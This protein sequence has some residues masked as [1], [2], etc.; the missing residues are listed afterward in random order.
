[1]KDLVL[2]S[3]NPGK[4][5]E[6]QTILNPI[7]CILQSSLGIESAEET[8]LSFIENALIKARHAS[9]IA[10]KPALADDS[11][12]V[13]PIIDGRPGIYSARFAGTHATDQQNIDH[14]L[15]ALNPY[16]DTD[17]QA[18]F[19]CALAFVEHADDPTPI[20]ATAAFHGLI[21]LEPIGSNGFGY[22]PIFY[23]PEH[24]CT[25]AQLPAHIKNKISHRA[26]ALK[27]LQL[28]LQAKEKN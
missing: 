12:L 20:I 15:N 23:I 21:G 6:F 27:Q 28:Q 4:L 8:G 10:E 1:M 17:R 26:L 22:D 19:Y 14:L 25:A 18:Y 9:R 3:S 7:R 11:G 16:K 2:A 5:L 13:V 24:R